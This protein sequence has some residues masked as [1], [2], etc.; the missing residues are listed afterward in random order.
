MHARVLRALEPCAQGRA[1]T[2]LARRVARLM[3]AGDS[4]CCAEQARAVRED[5]GLLPRS[6][7]PGVVPANSKRD[8]RM[9]G[10]QW[11]MV[12]ALAVIGALLALLTGCGSTLTTT[13][14]EVQFTKEGELSFLRQ[15]T[16]ETIAQIDI[17][18]ADTPAERTQGLMYRRSLPAD[19]GMLFIFDS[20]QPLTFWMKDTFISLDMVFV[21]D[22]KEI[23][24]IAR[25]TIPLSEALIP[26]GGDAMYVVEVN[27]G[28]CDT[29]GIR[30]GD[31]I[32]FAR[33]SAARV[34]T[35]RLR[36]D[37]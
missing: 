10:W 2:V 20:A 24:S 32:D 9:V 33:T 6:R 19:A 28:F 35:G 22:S 17:E 37:D 13:A 11:K 21:N 14:P 25:S 18:I 29:H 16:A 27:A 7:S 15:A 1:A 12:P 3:V 23:V 4:R 8:D 26:S 30:E 31:S 36:S 34:A 5:H